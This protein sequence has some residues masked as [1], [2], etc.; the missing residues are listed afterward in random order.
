MLHCVIDI[1]IKLEVSKKATSKWESHIKLS[2]AQSA[3]VCVTSR[4]S[5]GQGHRKSLASSLG[6]QP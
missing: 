6:A 2:A 1:L 3:V 4:H 5:R